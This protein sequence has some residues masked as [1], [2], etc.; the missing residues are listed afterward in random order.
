MNFGNFLFQFEEPIKSE[1]PA[2][3]NPNLLT[4]GKRPRMHYEGSYLMPSEPH[5]YGPG[6]PPYSFHDPFHNYVPWLQPW[7]AAYRNWPISTTKEALKS[8][9]VRDP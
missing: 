6:P 1:S 7:M 2:P 8:L 5:V 3:L 9:Q 4:N